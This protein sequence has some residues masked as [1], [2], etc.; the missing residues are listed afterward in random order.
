MVNTGVVIPKV[1]TLVSATLSEIGFSFLSIKFWFILLFE[2]FFFSFVEFSI[3]LNGETSVGISKILFKI[4]FLLVS[5]NKG[6][7]FGNFLLLFSLSFSLLEY[8]NN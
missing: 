1:E 6:K 8:H 7:E 3:I 2:I 5:F 4:V